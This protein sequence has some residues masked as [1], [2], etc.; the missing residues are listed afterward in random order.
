MKTK[1][2][3]SESEMIQSRISDKWSNNYATITESAEKLEIGHYVEV[4]RK[5]V[6]FPWGK[7]SFPITVNFN[8]QL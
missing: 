1:T 3:N 2:F 7:L 4:S 5:H 8:T 6:T